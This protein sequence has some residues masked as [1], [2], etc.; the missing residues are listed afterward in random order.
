MP[1]NWSQEKYDE[2]P[3]RRDTEA[4][5]TRSGLPVLIWIFRHKKKGGNTMHA[6]SELREWFLDWLDGDNGQFDDG[7]IAKLQELRSCTDELPAGYCQHRR[8]HVPFGVSY[9]VAAQKMLTNKD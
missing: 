7:A 8:L 5:T 1:T 2:L 6:T 3:H 9:G 4:E